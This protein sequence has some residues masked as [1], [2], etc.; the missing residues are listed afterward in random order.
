MELR[1]L[2]DL[3]ILHLLG[4]FQSSLLWDKI[5][6]VDEIYEIRREDSEISLIML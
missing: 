4:I 6:P 2:K 3:Y 1:E 5:M